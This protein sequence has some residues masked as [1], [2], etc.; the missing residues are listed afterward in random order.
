MKRFFAFAGLMTAAA[1]SLTNC[2]VKEISGE[3]LPDR[4][5]TIAASTDVGTRTTNDGMSTLWEAV[6]TVNVFYTT[7]GTTY[8]GAKGTVSAGGGTTRATFDVSGDVPSGEADWYVFFPYN[9]HMTAPDGS[10]GYNYIGH[11]KGITQDGFDNMSALRGNVCPMYGSVEG[12]TASEALVSMKHLTSVI[13]FSI[14]NNTG[15]SF[16]VNS[17]TLT[18]S[19]DIVGTYYIDFVSDTPTYTSSGSSYV[20]NSAKVNMEDSTLESG[21]SGKVYLPIKPY[22]QSESE[23]F[24]VVLDCT[25]GGAAKT[26]TFDL[27]PTGA[28]A[29]FSAGKIKPVALNV[30]QFEGKVYN[31][32]ADA[33]NGTAGSSYEIEE[34]L[35]TVVVGNNVFATDDTGTILVYNS[36]NTL[37]KGDKISING[38]TKAYNNLVEFSGATVTK[39]GEGTVSIS[40]VEWTD[41]QMAAA[42]GDAKIAYVSYTV[43]LTDHN[44]GTIPGSDAILYLTKAAGVSTSKDKTYTLTGYVY[45]WYNNTTP[46]VCMFVD[47]ATEVITEETLSASPSSVSIPQEGGSADVTV[48][49]DDSNWTIDTESVPTWLTATRSDNTITFSAGENTDTKRSATI[50]LTHS[51]GTLTATVK[52]SQEGAVASDAISLSPASLIFDADSTTPQTV[53]VTSNNTDWYWDTESVEEWITITKSGTQVIV[54][55]SVNTGDARS[56]TVKFTHSNGTKNANL[57]IN[58]RA[59]VSGTKATFTKVTSGTVGAGDYLI[60]YEDGNKALDGSLTDFS[61]TNYIDVTINGSTI[62]ADPSICVTFDPSAQTLKTASGCYLGAKSNN[63]NGISS[64]KSEPSTDIYKISITVSDGIATIYCTL[65]AGDHALRYNVDYSYFRFYKPS[66]SIATELAIYKKN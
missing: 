64:T 33:L 20:Y 7:D 16:I 6:D 51:N 5:F 58:Q 29:V 34:A 22:T 60:V 17:V 61:K 11:S 54:S 27:N 35:V 10:A 2:Q 47:S 25:V 12:K 52:V 15:A 57:V 49:S 30:T 63:N 32:V 50:T 66:S 36:K 23:S 53:E 31:T 3:F 43:S 1:I 55:V 8:T 45:G 62:T 56:C 37:V 39:T 59:P 19:E 44:K 42:Y 41:A 65:E 28:Q 14:T 9:S 21:E 13:E 18:A 38:K 48:T 40:P 46:Q 24:H 4:T 26:A